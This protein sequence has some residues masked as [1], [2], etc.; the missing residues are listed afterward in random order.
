MEPD[1]APAPA[2]PVRH[3]VGLLLLASL[4]CSPRQSP[5][6]PR[7]VAVLGSSSAAGVGPPSGAS[8]VALLQRAA[9]AECPQVSLVNLAVPGYTTAQALP[10]TDAREPG[11]RKT[12]PAHGL[13]AALAL[14]P[15]LVLIQFPSNDAA[16]YVPLE[17]TLRNHARLRDGVRASG[18]QEVILGPFPRAFQDPDQVKLLTGLRDALPAVAGARYL[19]LWSEL[20]A[21]DTE[22]LAAFAAGDGIHLNAAAHQLL[23]RKVQASGAWRAVCIR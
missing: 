8:W 20:A 3:L 18:A 23:A 5:A 2:A 1:P 16:A 14:H 11:E 15:M 13:A 4:A 21:S 22:V 19:P 6:R 10:E 7:V 17:A 12:D 9:R